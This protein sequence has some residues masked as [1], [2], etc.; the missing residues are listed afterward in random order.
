MNKLL[1]FQLK[2]C[3]LDIYHNRLRDL[4]KF[5][6][7]KYVLFIRIV[8]Y[9]SWVIKLRSVKQALVVRCWYFPYK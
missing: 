2:L 6:I 4:V 9:K 3:L 1:D 5:K 7:Y 8:I